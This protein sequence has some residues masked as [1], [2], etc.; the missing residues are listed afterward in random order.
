MKTLLPH[1]LSV[2]TPRWWPGE[3]SVSHCKYRSALWPPEEPERTGN[4]TLWDCGR[5]GTSVFSPKH[6]DCCD[7]NFVI[8]RE[9]SAEMGQS[10][11][12][13]TSGSTW[14]P[15]LSMSKLSPNLPLTFWRVQKGLAG[16]IPKSLVW[17]RGVNQSNYRKKWISLP[18]MSSIFP[19]FLF[20][21]LPQIYRRI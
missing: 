10:C 18:P 3:Q 20:V 14:R 6:S 2:W 21:V 5:P 11:S 19:L 17:I 4:I 8:G 16:H 12:E 9:G 7:R 15:V 1:L 13:P